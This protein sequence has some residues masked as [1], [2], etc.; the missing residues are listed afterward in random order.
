MTDP[1]L[2]R[3][4]GPG[5]DM[6]RCCGHVTVGRTAVK[7]LTAPVLMAQG[8]DVDDVLEVPRPLLPCKNKPQHSVF[9]L[10]GQSRVKQPTRGDLS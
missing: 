6:L 4:D 7:G 2:G 9:P 5:V 3:A 1:K 10:V 8:A